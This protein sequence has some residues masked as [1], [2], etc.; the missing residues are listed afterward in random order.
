MI[1]TSH[2]TTNWHKSWVQKWNH[3]S[4]EN[5]FPA[6]RINPL[7]PNLKYSLLTLITATPTGRNAG[8]TSTFRHEVGSIIRSRWLATQLQKCKGTRPLCAPGLAPGS[9]GQVPRHIPQPHSNTNNRSRGNVLAV[10][11]HLLQRQQVLRSQGIFR[12][13]ALKTCFSKS[14]PTVPTLRYKRHTILIRK[15]NASLVSWQDLRWMLY[16]ST[17]TIAISVPP[18]VTRPWRINFFSSWHE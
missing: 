1:T 16:S 14:A 9:A 15:M 4:R 11:L 6:W 17:I 3:A 18:T 13:N 8:T 10:T 5:T 7:K 2:S 12:H